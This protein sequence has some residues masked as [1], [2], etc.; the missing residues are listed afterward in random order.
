MESLSCAV[1]VISQKVHTDIQ[2]LQLVSGWTTLIVTRWSP[3]LRFV[4][5]VALHGLWI[6]SACTF[7]YDLANK[8][9]ECKK[10]A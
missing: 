1:A 7:Q 8:K 10:Q 9:A 6:T 2:V 4:L 3:L 5:A